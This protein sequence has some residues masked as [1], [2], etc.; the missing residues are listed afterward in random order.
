MKVKDIMKSPVHSI[1][2]SS[3][4]SKAVNMMVNYS[5]G[6]VLITDEVG[7]PWS[8]ITES[9]IIRILHSNSQK[10]ELSWLW[11]RP[12]HS[13]NLNA[14]HTISPNN[15]IADAIQQMAAYRIRRLPVVHN[16][17]LVGMIT[18]REIIEKMAQKSMK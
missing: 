14:L 8:I 17:R 16:E 12:L 13:F 11:I 2:N 6:A 10:N 7:E 1:K 3:P 4:P 5:I 9:D 18:E 15:R